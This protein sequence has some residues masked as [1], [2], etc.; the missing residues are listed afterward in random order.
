MKKDVWTNTKTL[1]EFGTNGP[2]GSPRAWFRRALDSNNI[3]DVTFKDGS[4]TS[5]EISVAGIWYRPCSVPI[6]GMHRELFRFY[7][8]PQAHSITRAKSTVPMVSA[9][10]MC[11]AVPLDEVV[12][13]LQVY[14]DHGATFTWWSIPQDRAVRAAQPIVSN[15]RRTDHNEVFKLLDSGRNTQQISEIMNLPKPNIA[16]I[17]KKW[18]EKQNVQT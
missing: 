10:G 14:R 8:I 1:V 6:T 15:R 4:L 9:I 17:A 13:W 2:L 16:Y 5:Y 7:K 18:R 11:A 12:S 3:D